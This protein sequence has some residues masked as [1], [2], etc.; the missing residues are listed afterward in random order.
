MS[1]TERLTR[2]VRP[3]R[4]GQITIPAEFRK[5]LCIDQET[6]LRLTLEAGE[7]RIVPVRV[8][9][10]NEGPDWLDTLYELYAPV[11]AEVLARGIPEEEVNADIDAA[12]AAVR[13]EQHAARV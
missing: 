7:L 1:E 4:S 5:R 6:L 13:A 10:R 8:A 11:R 12:I 3:L 2:I 9:E